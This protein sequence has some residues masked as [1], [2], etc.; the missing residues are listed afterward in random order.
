MGIAILVRH[1][2]STANASGTLTGRLPGIQLSDTGEQQ[3][4]ELRTAFADVTVD[5]VSVSP[6]ERTVRTAQV[7]FGDRVLIEE[8]GI[9]ECDY[10]DWSG[11]LLSELAEEPLWKV[12]QSAPGQARFPNGE[13]MAA[14]AERSLR[15]VEERATSD[16]VHV[17]VSHGDIIKALISHAAGAEFDKFQRIVVDPC[18]VS[19]IRYGPSPV[20][21]ASNI[22]PSGAVAALAGLAKADRGTVG[23]GG[24]VA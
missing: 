7:I 21:L 3:A 5:T 10:G 12:V 14:M 2:H 1:G 15:A 8:P 13:A 24:G 22:P 6:M 16:G 18:S 9:I 11:R 17:F 20:L 23:G 4:R 19:I